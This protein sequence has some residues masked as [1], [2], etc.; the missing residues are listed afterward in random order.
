MFLLF[1]DPPTLLCLSSNYLHSIMFLL[2]RWSFAESKKPDLFT[3]HYVSIISA[4]IGSSGYSA[5]IF[6]F[7]YVS[8]ISCGRFFAPI[9]RRLW[10]TFH[11]VSIISNPSASPAFVAWFIYIP[12]CFYYFHIFYFRFNIKFS[13]TFHYVSII[14]SDSDTA[15]SF[16]FLFTFHYVSIISTIADG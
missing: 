14:S 2:F 12:L 7:H 13:F 16:I 3:F 5:Q 8:I 10:F 4:Q 6:T 9:L 1:Q 11:Y 15:A